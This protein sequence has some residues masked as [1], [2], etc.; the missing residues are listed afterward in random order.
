[1]KYEYLYI[2]RESNTVVQL[3]YDETLCEYILDDGEWCDR[4]DL[5][6]EENKEVLESLDKGYKCVWAT[7]KSGDT[8]EV[9]AD[10]AKAFGL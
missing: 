3:Y 9:Y 2:Y 7:F 5:S 1:M 8:W 4:L 6:D 10:P